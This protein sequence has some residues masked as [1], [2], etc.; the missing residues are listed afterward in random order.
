MY[1]VP[2][3]STRDTCIIAHAHCTNL[4]QNL[5]HVQKGNTDVIRMHALRDEQFMVNLYTGELS[6]CNVQCSQCHWYP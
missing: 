3:F 2:Q 1:A 5:I 6:V 4:I